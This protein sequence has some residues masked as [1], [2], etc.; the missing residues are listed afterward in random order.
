[1][2]AELLVSEVRPTTLYEQGADM[3]ETGLGGKARD[4]YV[5]DTLGARADDRWAA[6][7]TTLDAAALSPPF[8][9]GSCCVAGYR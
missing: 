1:M 5:S 3:F 2:P 9:S 4:D 7:T 8:P 6:Q